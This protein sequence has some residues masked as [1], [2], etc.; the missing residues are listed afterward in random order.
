MQTEPTIE[1]S[2][3]SKYY[4]YIAVAFVAILMISNTVAVKLIGLG[5][6]VFT[7]AF[8]IFPISYIFGDIL[9]EVYGYKATRKIIWAGFFTQILM[10]FCYWLVQVMPSASVW[11]N[12]G[13]YEAILGYVPRIVIASMIAYF[14]G[15]FTNSFVL[16]KMKI[17]TEGKHLWS[18]TIG[19][20]VVGQ[21]VDSVLF[22]ALAFAFTVPTNVLLVMIAV[23]Y[24]G[25]VLYEVI[26]TP[27][28]YVIVRKLKQAEG[29]DIYDKGIN[30]NPFVLKE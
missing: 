26:L 5:S 17:W 22:T 20:T 16:S 23:Q 2:K 14:C 1:V 8:L 3:N 19:S 7:G 28:T 13:A 12:Q 21:L 25:K 27:L 18:R 29:I 30:Y 6:L 10:V 15:E 9:T 4:L 24:F 11:P